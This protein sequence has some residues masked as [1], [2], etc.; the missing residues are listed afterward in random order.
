M[1]NL[2]DLDSSKPK[3]SIPKKQGV[4]LGSSIALAF[5]VGLI[6]YNMDSNESKKSEEKK[7]IVTAS[8]VGINDTPIELPELPIEPVLIKETLVPLDPLPVNDSNIYKQQMDREEVLLKIESAQRRINSPTEIYKSKSSEI[9]VGNNQKYMSPDENSQFGQMASSQLVEKVSASQESN[10][11]WKIFQGKTIPAVLDT[12]INSDLPAMIRASISEDVYGETGRQILL[13]KGTRLIGQY[14]SA[15]QMGQVR[16]FVIWTRAITPDQVS[17]AL[18]SSGIDTLGR[19]GMSGEVDNHFWDIFGTS[20]L[21]SV[22]AVGA[23]DMDTPNSDTFYGNPYQM[24]VVESLTGQS[25]RILSKRLNIKPT[26]A[27]DQGARINVM[28]AKDLDFTST[29]SSAGNV[30]YNP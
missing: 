3:V 25:D 5:L 15:I 9:A 18:G 27:V 12:A 28:V 13:P 10:T 21:L 1:E 6:W 19:A 23:A 14:N 30:I 26:I 16:V 7:H 17:I 22:M 4:A 2:Q 29:Q 11:D 20:I 8:Q 24:E